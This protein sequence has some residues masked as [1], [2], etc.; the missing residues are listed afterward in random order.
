MLIWCH[1]FFGTQ[2]G[3]FKVELVSLSAVKRKSEEGSEK[4]SFVGGQGDQAE[5]TED[6]DVEKRADVNSTSWFSWLP[7]HCVVS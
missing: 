7:S 3:K 6:I 4:G 5:A 2:E 1:S